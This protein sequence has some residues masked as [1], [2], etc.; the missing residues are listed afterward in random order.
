M[1][2]MTTLLLSIGVAY[3]VLQRA[4]NL[5]DY[6]IGAS[7]IVTA[8]ITLQRA[9]SEDFLLSETRSISWKVHL[10]R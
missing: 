3:M 5:T 7:L 6:L 9:T 10:Q 8:F 4:T 2:A 1:V